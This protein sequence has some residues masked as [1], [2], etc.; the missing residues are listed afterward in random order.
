MHLNKLHCAAL[1]TGVWC[2]SNLAALNII[3]YSARII[4][5]E[6]RL[7][8]KY[9]EVVNFE[10]DRCSCIHL[11]MLSCEQHRICDRM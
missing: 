8:R 3:L 5:Y 6:D 1:F 9:S 2:S 11:H 10:F 4:K 7:P